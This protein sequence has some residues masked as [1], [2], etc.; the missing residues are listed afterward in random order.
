M[1]I[2][3]NRGETY[4]NYQSSS[5]WLHME[6]YSIL[7]QQMTPAIIKIPKIPANKNHPKGSQN[8]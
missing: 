5:D 3:Q 2:L 4:V 1:K 7:E 8:V 6:Q